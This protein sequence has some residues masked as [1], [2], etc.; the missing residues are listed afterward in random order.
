MH[1]TKVQ[2]AACAIGLSLICC[3]AHAQTI[4]AVTEENPNLH[5]AGPGGTVIGPGADLVREVLRRAGL[6]FEIK[7]FPWP[8]AY[9]LAERE[10]NVLIFSIG[11]TPEREDKFKWVG[12]IIA[13]EY[14]F[15]KLKTRSDISI[16][17]LDDARRYSIGVVKQDLTEQFL[18]AR[19]FPASS[20]D[21]A[22]DFNQNLAKLL[23]GRTDLMVSSASDR[24]SICLRDASIC[25]RIDT[26]M[27][28]DEMKT[29][30][31]MAFSNQTPD[32]T[33][34][35]ARAA[36]DSMRSDGTWKRIM[37]GVK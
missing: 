26:A 14:R 35:R 25:E 18:T 21:A 17:T 20:L 10:P 22:I 33:V 23:A 29:T 13:T 32:D 9:T 6:S 36:Y 24:K 34:A 28:I 31:Y 11:R 16:Q 5:T 1:K 12:E 2:R 7:L 37:G 15:I 19:G 3:F 30:L 4:E 27:L 8:R